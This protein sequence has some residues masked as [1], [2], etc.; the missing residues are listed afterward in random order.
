MEPLDAEP[1]GVGKLLPGVRRANL[2]GARIG[3][4]PRRTVPLAVDDRGNLSRT[5]AHA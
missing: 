5:S 1:A 4:Q 2:A 3:A